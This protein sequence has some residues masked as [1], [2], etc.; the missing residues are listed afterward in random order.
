[1]R[2]VMAVANLLLIPTKVSQADVETFPKVNELIGL[3]RGLNPELK[4][5][6]LLSIAPSNPAIREV[7]SVVSHTPY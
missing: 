3:A 7:E 5:V 4:A 1:M 6:A 2:S